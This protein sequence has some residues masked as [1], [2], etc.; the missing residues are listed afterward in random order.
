MGQRLAFVHGDATSREGVLSAYGNDYTFD[1][2]CSLMLNP[3][4]V[5]AN[6]EWGD[7]LT[8]NAA[9]LIYAI[10]IKVHSMCPQEGYSATYVDGRYNESWAT[11]YTWHI[12]GASRNTMLP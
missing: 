10:N 3:A 6:C 9:M 11:L 5:K 4:G 12:S 8:L 1:L 2:Y 7:A